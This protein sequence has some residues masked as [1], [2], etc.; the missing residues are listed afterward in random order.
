MNDFVSAVAAAVPAALV[1]LVISGLFLYYLRWW[2][3]KKLRDEEEHRKKEH[4]LRVKRNQLEMQ[5]RHAA[6]RLFFWMHHAMVKPPPNGELEE[7]FEDYQRAEAEQ[8]A[9]EQ[10]ILADVYGYS[11]G[12]GE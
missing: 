4:E 7:A 9:Y 12:A 5:R 3:D 11:G 6:G 10:K 2:I 1:S 8:K